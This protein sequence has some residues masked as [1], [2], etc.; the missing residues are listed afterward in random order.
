[1]GT[2]NE[3]FVLSLPFDRLRANGLRP[4]VVSLSNH[5]LRVNGKKYVFS[6]MESLGNI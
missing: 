5:K 2:E 6:I 1:M 3:P 4:I